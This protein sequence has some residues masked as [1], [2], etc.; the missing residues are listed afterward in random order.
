MKGFLWINR[1]A[2]ILNLLYLICLFLRYY[3]VSLPESVV[4]FLI[5]GGWLLSFVFN[6]LLIGWFVALKLKKAYAPASVTL[7]RSNVLIFLFQI[8]YF[9]A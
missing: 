3:T 5:I 6:L 4:S 9:I 2:F 7:F 1:V 8:L